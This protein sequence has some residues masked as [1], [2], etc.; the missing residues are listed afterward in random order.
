MENEDFFEI[1]F[2]L[3]KNVTK[4]LMADPSTQISLISIY[5]HIQIYAYQTETCL[6]NFFLCHSISRI[7]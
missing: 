3:F 1:D 2:A 4:S 7:R 6:A 5:R